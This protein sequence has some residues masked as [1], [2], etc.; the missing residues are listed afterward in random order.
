MQVINHIV[1]QWHH[2]R[3][4]W[5]LLISH[6]FLEIRHQQDRIQ[7]YHSYPGGLGSLRIARTQDVYR[8][9]ASKNRSARA[10][11][12]LLGPAFLMIS[13]RR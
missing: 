3:K 4:S 12:F 1:S 8:G 9:I 13:W 10:R 5:K 6:Y 7:D 2:Y 11:E